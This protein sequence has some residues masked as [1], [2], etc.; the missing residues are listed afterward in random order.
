MKTKI[1]WFVIGFVVSWMA[2]SVVSY[3]RLHPRDY[4]Q[5]WSDSD[6]ENASGVSGWLKL[7]KGR[8]LGAFE[9]FTPSVS[10]N[11]SAALVPLKPN[12]FPQ[13]WIQ[14]FD[15]DGMPDSILVTDLKHTISVD[16]KDG[17]GIFDSYGY[18]IEGNT[19]S[20]SYTDFNMDGQ[21]DMRLNPDNTAS[22][23][24]GSQWHDLVAKGK[25]R[26]VDINGILTQVEAVDGVWGIIEE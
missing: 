8:K 7:A 17:D 2:W 4:T 19:N 23:F 10:S 5:S 20:I 1:T 13:V 26:Y 24:I 3:I 14:D 16:D 11:A 25:E 15:E 18:A 22:A 9:V 6:K 21:Y 12:C